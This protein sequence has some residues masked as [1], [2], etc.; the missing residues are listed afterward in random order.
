MEN[1]LAFGEWF[2]FAVTKHCP[3]MGEWSRLLWSWTLFFFFFFF[4]SSQVLLLRLSPKAAAEQFLSLFCP[5]EFVV[6]ALPSFH[7]AV[8]LWSLGELLQDI[9]GCQEKVSLV[10]VVN[11]CYCVFLHLHKENPLTPMLEPSSYCHVTDFTSESLVMNS[12]FVIVIHYCNTS[13]LHFSSFYSS[14][15]IRCIL[16]R[17]ALG[18]QKLQTRGYPGREV[19]SVSLPFV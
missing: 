5:F 11:G 6:W 12:F 14:F 17:S 3:N 18:E 1:A 7:F 8:Y 16:I 19:F 4:R 13:L 2:F 10:V 15:P 9:N